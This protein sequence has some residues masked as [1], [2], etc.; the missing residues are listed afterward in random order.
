MNRP[1]IVWI[2]TDQQRPDSLG[3]YGNP[4]VRSPHIDS[5]AR[6]GARFNRHLTPMQICSPSRATMV[7]GLYPRNHQLATN[8]MALPE[9]RPTL[10]TRL[11]GAGY[12][13]HGVGQAA[14]ATAAGASRD[15]HARL[16]SI[17]DQARVG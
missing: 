9:S 11:A 5:I 3:C 15:E 16:A 2:C 7:T 8:G 13:T 12:R 1:N 17:L 6:A 10:M 14:P 4:I